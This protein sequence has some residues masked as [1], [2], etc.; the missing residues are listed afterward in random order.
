MASGR[1]RAGHITTKNM[2]TGEVESMAR[3]SIGLMMLGVGA[4]LFLALGVLAGWRL[5]LC[6]GLRRGGGQA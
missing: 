6:L 5:V 3:G 2:E 4:V 1:S